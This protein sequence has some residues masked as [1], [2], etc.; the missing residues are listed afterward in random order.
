MVKLTK[1]S[2][3]MSV[4]VCVCTYCDCSGVCVSVQVCVAQLNAAS[5]GHVTGA[6]INRWSLIVL[7]TVLLQ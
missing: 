3:H 4:C 5:L 2:V 7:V 6:G 1:L